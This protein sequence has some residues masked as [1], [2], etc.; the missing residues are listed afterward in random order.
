MGRDVQWETIE[1]GSVIGLAEMPA[2]LNIYISLFRAWAQSDGPMW[3]EYDK[4]PPLGEGLYH[5][6]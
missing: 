4:V 3:V 2:L 5:E 6:Q 1:Y